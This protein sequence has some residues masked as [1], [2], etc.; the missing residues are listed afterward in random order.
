MENLDKKTFHLAGIIPVAGEQLDFG[1]EWSDSMMPIAPN[2]TALEHAVVECAWAGCE[3]VWIICNDDVSPL[4]RHRIGDYI[5][6]PVWANRTFDRFP[7]ESKKI[8]PIF[9]DNNQ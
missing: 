3:T 2:Y 4:I 9:L 1:F 8:I 6:D 7:S 5:L